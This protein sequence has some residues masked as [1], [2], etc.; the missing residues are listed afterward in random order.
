MKVSNRLLLPVILCFTLVFGI[1]FPMPT[2]D[3]G[4]D[5]PDAVVSKPPEKGNIRMVSALAEDEYIKTA[6]AAESPDASLDTDTN[7]D[8]DTVT[9]ADTDTDPSAV[10][11]RIDNEEIRL[12]S[13]PLLAD[14]RIYVP[15]LEF[16]GIMGQATMIP[17]DAGVT[18]FINNM[19]ITAI[20]DNCYFTA[21]GRYLYAPTLCKM[22]DDVMFVP[23]RPLAKAFGAV[24]FWDNDLRAVSVF[25]ELKPFE[26]G[27]TYYNETDLYWMSRIISAEARGEC[28]TGKI[29]VGNVVMNRMY[30]SVYPNTVRGVIFDNSCGVQFTPAYSGAINHTPNQEC[31]IAAKL[32]LD[33]ADVV[34]DSMFFNVAHLSSWASRNRTYVTTIGNHSFYA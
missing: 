2:A 30:S 7:T 17:D 5:K 28:F 32:A 8:A 3:G 33:G 14:S 23:I 18:V 25:T 12:S 11:I 29:A 20:S 31:V 34:G 21:N 24:V 22:V 19:K 10:T 9:D 13:P 1:V 15:L 4:P 26:H 6:P 27:D 16:C